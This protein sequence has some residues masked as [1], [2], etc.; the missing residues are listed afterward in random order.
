MYKKVKII[1]VFNLV[2]STFCLA[3]KSDML[4]IVY[5]F[6]NAIMNSSPNCN[7]EECKVE[8]YHKLFANES[9]STSRVYRETKLPINNTAS[10][11]MVPISTF[12]PELEIK[13]DTNLTNLDSIK[14]NFVAKSLKNG[15]IV[16]N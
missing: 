15:K 2:L 3:Q 4:K 9:K 1:V 12:N 6:E 13:L 7:K 14:I 16:Y 5:D 8:I 11:G 10:L